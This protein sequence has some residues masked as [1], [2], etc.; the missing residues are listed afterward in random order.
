MF[1]PCELKGFWQ[2]SKEWGDNKLG[3]SNAKI[4]DYGCTVSSIVTLGAWYCS[5]YTPATG[6]KKWSFT[7]NGAI[8]W[9]SI[10]DDKDYP[11]NFKHRYYHYDKTKIKD[12]LMSE[13]DSVIVAV[14]GDSHW[15]AIV[16]H[17]NRKGFK[18]YDPFYNDYI[19]VF[20]RYTSISGFT[21]F[22][23]DDKPTCNQCCKLHCV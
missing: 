18:C 20:D 1:T 11:M 16:G 2:R 9:Q 13:S 15:V 10:S 14:N 4:K 3:Q 5:D 6:A 23:R 19:Y 17:S 8:Y 12:I 7:G 22:T 21:H